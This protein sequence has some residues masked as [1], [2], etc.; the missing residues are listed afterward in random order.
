MT[1]EEIDA[2]VAD[3][4]RLKEE[5]TKLSTEK[6]TLEAT[7]AEKDGIIEK[8][9]QDIVGARRKYKKLDELTEEEKAAMSE[10]DIEKKKD[11]DLLFENQEADRLQR[12]ADRT[13]EI[14]ERRNNAV[15][16]FVGDDAALQAK[17]LA[18][19]DKIKDSDAAYTDTEIATFMGTAFNM[20]GEERPNPVRD[21]NN[22]GGGVAPVIGSPD[23]GTG[24][25][26]TEGGRGLAATMGLQSAQVAP[27]APPAV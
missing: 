1:Q 5:N 8:K 13:K 26:E 17:V 10:D 24:F 19:F 21:V 7:V 6:S 25:A 23:N 12:E 18:N 16:K 9:N 14:T 22:Q 2:M 4:A 3:N 20:L 27:P 15:R 11:Q